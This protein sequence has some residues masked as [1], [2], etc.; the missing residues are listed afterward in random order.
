VLDVV[1]PGCCAIARRTA[2]PAVAVAV[3]LKPEPVRPADV[4]MTWTGP[5]VAGMIGVKLATPT[6]SVVTVVTSSVSTPRT[7]V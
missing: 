2:A 5:T 6:P 3:K 1:A 7:V 4:T